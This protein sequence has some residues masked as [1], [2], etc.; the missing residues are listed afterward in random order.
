MKVNINDVGGLVV[1]DNETY[2]L[3]DNTSLKNLVL[4]S[5][6]L[7]SHRSTNGHS[8]PGQEEVYFFVSGTG[9]MYLNNVGRE[10]GP[11]DVVL[12]EDGIHHRVVNDTLESLYFVCV[13][14]GKRNHWR[15]LDWY[16]KIMSI[17]TSNS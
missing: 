12:I 14:D 10:V 16:L 7:K 4:S 3:V 6:E 1:K 11:G 5:T 9:T 2:R 17:L 13:F 15:T 8:H